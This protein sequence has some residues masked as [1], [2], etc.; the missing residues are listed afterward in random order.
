MKDQRVNIKRS[1]KIERKVP[2]DA[3]EQEQEVYDLLRIKGE[4]Q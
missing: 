1:R 3:R 2:A 4:R